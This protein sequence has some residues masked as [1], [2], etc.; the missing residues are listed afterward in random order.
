MT[1][2]TKKEKS[3]AKKFRMYNSASKTR[4]LVD[5]LGNTNISV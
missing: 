4:R 5:Y 1:D 3:K 2:A